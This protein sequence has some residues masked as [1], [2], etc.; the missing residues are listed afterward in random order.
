[1]QEEEPDLEYLISYIPPIPRPELDAIQR[2]LS[3]A[4]PFVPGVALE[5]QE[6]SS[7]IAAADAVPGGVHPSGGSKHCHA[8]GR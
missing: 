3:K 7:S 1:M 4:D 2:V 8:L 5:D 6:V